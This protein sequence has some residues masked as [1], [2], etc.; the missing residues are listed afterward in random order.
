[1]LDPLTPEEESRHR[2]AIDKLRGRLFRKYSQGEWHIVPASERILSAYA[3]C[4]WN[5]ACGNY[6][7]VRLGGLSYFVDCADRAGLSQVAVS[8][9]D[10]DRFNFW[11][12]AA[13]GHTIN[14]F[15]IRFR[16]LDE[17]PHRY[18]Q[19]YRRAN[20]APTYVGQR[21]HPET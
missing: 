11:L 5:A 3:E 13:K 19:S 6:R 14:A 12:S 9:D 15:T 18:V 4:R 8:H 21:R 20:L 17:I 1:M 16:A 7:M 10:A 2:E